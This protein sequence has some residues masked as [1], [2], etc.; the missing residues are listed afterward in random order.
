L[1][2]L[3]DD[4]DLA[5]LLRAG[6]ASDWLDVQ[7]ITLRVNAAELAPHPAGA[8]PQAAQ[9]RSAAPNA[10]DLDLLELAASDGAGGLAPLGSPTPA[11]RGPADA[12]RDGSAHARYLGRSRVR[13]PLDRGD[14]PAQGL[15]TS[16]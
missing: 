14:L 6:E 1:V 13:S 16:P 12:V 2:A 11:S 5:T 4:A 9:P 8:A 10:A 3:L 15:P 7:V